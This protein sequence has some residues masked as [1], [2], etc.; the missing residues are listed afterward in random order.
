ML[1]NKYIKHSN[2]KF[3]QAWLVTKYNNEY[4]NEK[5]VEVNFQRYIPK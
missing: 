1:F 3:C 5:T 2:S 4:K